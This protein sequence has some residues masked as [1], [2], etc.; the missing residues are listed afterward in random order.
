MG[1]SFNLR[2]PGSICKV[3]FSLL[4]HLHGIESPRAPRQPNA[5]WKGE[6]TPSLQGLGC[7]LLDVWPSLC[8]RPCPRGRAH[9]LALD[10]TSILTSPKGCVQPPTLLKCKRFSKRCVHHFCWVF[11][12]KLTC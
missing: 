10:A 8:R 11:S 12:F 1:T 2:F 7:R 4:R 5:L 6:Q 9:L 3:P